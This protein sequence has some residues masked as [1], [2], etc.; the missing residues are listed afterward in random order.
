VDME[1]TVMS[2][3]SQTFSL[4]RLL[5]LPPKKAWENCSE[6]NCFK[7]T[8]SVG[9]PY[10]NVATVVHYETEDNIKERSAIHCI[11]ICPSLIFH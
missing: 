2:V 7:I 10:L 5:M 1:A 11:Y 8:L 3:M 9:K 6:E 4:V